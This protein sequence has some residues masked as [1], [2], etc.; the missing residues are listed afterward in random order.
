[1]VQMKWVAKDG[2]AHISVN[3]FT[4]TLPTETWALCGTLVFDVVE[5]PAILTRIPIHSEAWQYV[6]VSDPPSTPRRG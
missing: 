6:R 5:W 4:R 3:V 2:P 1:M